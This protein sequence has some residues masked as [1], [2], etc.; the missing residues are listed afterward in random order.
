MRL[1]LV[2]GLC[3][4]LLVSA[5][6]GCKEQEPESGLL[7]DRGR[8]EF[9]YGRSCFFGCPLEQ[10]LLVGTQERIDLSDPGDVAGLK[11]T[12]SGSDVAEFAVERD[13]FCEREAD[14]NTRIEVKESASCRQGWRKHCDNSLVV[15]ALAAGQTKLELRDEDNRVIDTVSVTV[16]IADSV[17]FEAL[18]PN[19]LAAEQGTRFELEPGE[20]ME[21]EAFIYDEYE[22]RL[23]APEGVTWSVRD[24][25]VAIV[26]SWLEASGE[27]IENGSS[28]T[29]E[30]QAPG[31][32]RVFIAVPDLEGSLALEVAE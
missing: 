13:C 2:R 14:E 30:A 27:Q 19:A 12:T 26:S 28:V 4:V 22:I 6:A 21:V 7:G 5:A 29:V 3:L 8:V 11:I 25:E 9:S 24:P 1:R 18:L 16:G 31:S 32:T 10:P 20:S 15:Q 23:L 17:V